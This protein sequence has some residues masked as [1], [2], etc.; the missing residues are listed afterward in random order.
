MNLRIAVIGAGPAGA[1]AGWHLATRGFAVALVDAAAFPRDK[2]CG[3]WLTPLALAE[4]AVL[5]L[6]GA[7][8]DRAAPGHATVTTTRLAAPSRRASTHA[9]GIPGACIPRRVLDAL[10]RD[11]ALAAG[12]EPVQRAV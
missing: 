1:A 8:L 11:R 6:D 5:G 7:T 3:D 2:T 4:L 10:V 12:C 9:S